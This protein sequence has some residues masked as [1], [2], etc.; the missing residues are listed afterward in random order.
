MGWNKK[1][2]EAQGINTR[3]LGNRCKVSSERIIKI[4]KDELEKKLTLA[5]I[6]KMAKAMNCQFIYGFVTND[7]LIQTIESV[8]EAKAKS[9]LTRVSHSMKLEN[10]QVSN[11]AQKEQIEILKEE[12]LKGN[13]KKVW[14]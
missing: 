12:L 5:T 14:E 10:Q 3:K 13:I 1:V 7:G 9:Q 6:E 8:A 2:R 4:E 11:Q